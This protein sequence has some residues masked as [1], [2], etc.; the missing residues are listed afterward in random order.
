MKVQVL[1]AGCKKCNLLYQSLQSFVEKHNLNAEVEYTDDLDKLME[2]GV[3]M[4]PAVLIDGVKK[5]EGKIPTEAQFK[6]WF[7]V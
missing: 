7:Q 5:S 1:G 6:E 3:I 2:A 4:P